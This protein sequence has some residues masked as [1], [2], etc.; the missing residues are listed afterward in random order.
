M[1]V[2]WWDSSYRTK[3][4]LWKDMPTRKEYLLEGGET[5]VIKES[6]NRNCNKKRKFR[7]KVSC[8]YESRSDTLTTDWGAKGQSEFDLGDLA[9]N[10][11]EIIM[12][13]V[14]ND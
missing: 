1:Y 3:L 7:I 14:E 5:L 8:R 12:D 9:R 2:D 4:R 10:T 11:D 13:C 6:L